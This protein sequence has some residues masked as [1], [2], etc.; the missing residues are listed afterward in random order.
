MDFHSRTSQYGSITR[1]A[2]YLGLDAPLKEK[3]GAVL[4]EI[5][6]G[7]FAKEW[8]EQQ[9]QANALFEKIRA[10]REELPFTKW[11]TAARKAFRIGNA[12]LAQRAEGERSPS[13]GE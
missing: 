13:G 11:E 10:I 3:M 5:R 2:R 7:A 8:S 9:E 12:S 6:S 4:E 1:G